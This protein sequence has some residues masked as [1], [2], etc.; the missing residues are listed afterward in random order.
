MRAQHRRAEI[1]HRLVL[2]RDGDLRAELSRVQ[3]MLR[4]RCHRALTPLRRAREAADP[5]GHK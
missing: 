3:E 5:V 1:L 2:L 4:D